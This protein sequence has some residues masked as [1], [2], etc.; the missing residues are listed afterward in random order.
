MSDRF[1]TVIIG[2][3]VVG[4]AVARAIARQG[5]EVLILERNRLP[6]QEVSARNSGVIHSGIYYP[7]G[8]LKARLCVRGNSMLYAY[9]QARSLNYSRCGKLIVAQQGQSEALRALQ[10]KAVA[11]GVDDLRWLDADAV[12]GLEPL[13]RC[14]A[15]LFSPGTGIVDVH[16]L[17]L[18][19]IADIEECGG[20]IAYGV[21]ARDVEAGS[22][23]ITVRAHEKTQTSQ[24][25]CGALV[26]AAG[27][28]AVDLLQS[29]R[30]Y[31]VDRRRAAYFA[32]GCYFAVRGPKPF[33]HLV[34]PMPNEAGL[35]IHA[36]LDLQGATRFGPNV[37]WVESPE[38]S[39]DDDMLPEFYES[40]RT[41]WPGLPDGALHPDYAG[42][43]PKLVG[44]GAAAA[45]F[46]IEGPKD[47]GCAGL[48]NLLGME[49]PG[50]TS[51]LAIGE[52]VA[53][54]V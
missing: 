24:I 39:V 20:T 34:Y 36:T 21:D 30:G 52:Y 44:K 32:K 9:C 38:Y 47:H 35:G 5:R 18:A 6:A 37:V 3:G 50:L 15:A 31:P 8:S 33:R 7:P 54:L 16:E 13:V 17:V 10:A 43:R 49:S 53:G 22:A 45:D 42:V 48:V 41:Y 19:L 14:E 11:N 4:L 27:L 51:S 26:N 25:Q 2:A 40:I 28:S 29:V 12:R 1:D 23:T 46:L